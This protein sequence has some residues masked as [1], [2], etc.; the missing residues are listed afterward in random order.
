M[1]HENFP[2]FLDSVLLAFSDD[3]NKSKSIEELK[4][5]VFKDELSKGYSLDKPDENLQKLANSLFTY[6]EYLEYALNFLAQEGL[7]NYD[8]SKRKDEKSI[9]ITSKGFFK[10]KTEGFAKKIKSDKK[11]IKLQ[12]NT[13]KV[14]I[15]SLIV[16]V[17]SV[18]VS[19]YVSTKSTTQN[20]Q[21]N[22]S[23]KIHDSCSEK[24]PVKPTNVPDMLHK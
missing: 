10:I 13:L 9:T 12:K 21:N 5:I 1:F 22:T 24:H 23:S 15:F 4:I 6:I 16:S 3:Y 20:E 8:E 2:K 14:A 7:V 19:L 18:L 17:I 11:V